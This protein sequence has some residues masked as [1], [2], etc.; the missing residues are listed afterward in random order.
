MQA[1]AWHVPGYPSAP[2]GVASHPLR[3]RRCGRGADTDQDASGTV[4]G[5]EYAL[6]DTDL[7]A[8]DIGRGLIHDFCAEPKP[9]AVDGYAT[10]AGCDSASPHGCRCTCSTSAYQYGDI[11]FTGRAHQPTSPYGYAGPFEPAVLAP[12]A[13]GRVGHGGRFRA[14]CL[15]IG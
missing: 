10:P 1:T 13:G 4:S 5:D 7:D 6:T 11:A 9:S 12:T 3:V 14:G 8:D 15:P 2:D